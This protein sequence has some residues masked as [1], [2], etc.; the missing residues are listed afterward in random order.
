MI[1]SRK[2]IFFCTFCILVL[3]IFF[4]TPQSQFTILDDD[5]YVTQNERIKQFDTN[6]IGELFLTPSHG[7]YMPLTFLSYALEYHYFGLNAFVF[8]VTN[9][10]L[11]IAVSLLIYVLAKQLGLSQQVGWIASILFLIHP[12]HVEPVVWISG[13]KDLL[14]AFF[15]LLAICFYN[16]SQSKSKAYL[17]YISI[18]CAILSMLSKPMALSLPLVL[19]LIDW[20][21]ERKFTFTQLFEKVPF[22]LSLSL[23]ASI[24]FFQH[25]HIVEIHVYKSILIWVWCCMFHIFKFFFPF[26]LNPLYLLPEP[27]SLFKKDYLI[28]LMTFLLCCG[29]IIRLRHLRIVVFSSLFYF[30]SI[31]FLL[32]MDTYEVVTVADRYMYLP[33]IGIILMLSLALSHFTQKLE[34][35]KSVWS[36]FGSLGMGLIILGLIVQSFFQ[37][38]IWSNSLTLWSYLVKHSPSYASYNNMG[39][40]LFNKGEYEQS[41]IYFSK[42]IDIEPLPTGSL[43]NRGNAY[44]MLNQFDLALADYE[45]SIQIDP[46]HTKTYFNRGKLYFDSSD[47]TRLPLALRDYSLAIIT[48]PYYQKAYIKRAQIYQLLEQYQKALKD[49]NRGIKLNSK[50]QFAYFKRGILYESM[51][52]RDLA[53]AD[54][55][56]VIELVPKD[57]NAYLNRGVIY[58]KQKQYSMALEDF[59]AAISFSPDKGKLY[60]NRAQLY[61]MIGNSE[62]SSA[63][64]AK[65]NLLGFT[66]RKK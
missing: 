45:R 65:A 9:I 61:K 30:F 48:N 20:F 44:S 46:N 37:T 39:L 8:H 27:I 12:M 28:A 57:A 40:T 18:L 63:D 35:T 38:Q 5:V 49:F 31:F 10:L 52:H 62:K 21:Q 36:R 13:R 43:N 66:S 6:H 19:F 24:T 2:F 56:K 16:H 4:T 60:F 64:Y 22:I 33:S 42:A 58:A 15:Y 17:Y 26:H 41:V 53:I 55:D 11:H 51:N 23:I 7:S 54:F 25:F 50:D 29:F 1:I 32:K 59:N 3:T 47:V 14:C 34:S